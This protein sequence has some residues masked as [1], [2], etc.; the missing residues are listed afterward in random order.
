MLLHRLI[1]ILVIASMPG[2]AALP[3]FDS[4]ELSFAPQLILYELK[5][6]AMMQSAV[7][8]PTTSI[9]T[10]DFGADDR[11]SSYGGVFGYG[12]GFSGLQATFYRYDLDG[13]DSGTLASDFGNVPAGS[14]VRSEFTMD[15][16]RLGY[17]A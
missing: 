8:N 6:D 15:E 1:L 13:N 14:T 4:P 11:D 17:T 16:F 7:A 5:G 10:R 9:D 3:G 12:D 2:C